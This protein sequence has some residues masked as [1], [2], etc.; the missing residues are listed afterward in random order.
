MKK[1]EIVLFGNGK[2]ADV[3]LYYLQNHSE[4]EVVA[5]TVDREFIGNSSSWNDLPIIPFDQIKKEFP[6]KDYKMF[7]ALGY[8][9]LNKLRESKFNEAKNKG[10][11]LISYVHPDSGIPGDCKYGENCFIMQN[12]LIHPK[13]AIGNNVFVWSGAMIGHHSKIEDHC[14]LTSCSNLS[15]ELCLGKNSFVGVNATVT[16]KV[17][18]GKNCLLGAN[19]LL[20]KCTE[21][22]QVFLEEP[23]DKFRLDSLQ[24]LKLSKNF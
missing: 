7:I 6:C 8:Q 13:V 16:E 18:I 9:E 3:L 17:E 21:N 20:T 2:I 12:C 11:S 15:S 1:T 5:I 10:Y 23:T 19:T 14:W 22:D 24:F 4:Y